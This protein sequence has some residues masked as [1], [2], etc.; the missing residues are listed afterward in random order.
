MHAFGWEKLITFS[1]Q[2]EKSEPA[3]QARTRTHTDL[4]DAVGVGELEL[5]DVCANLVHG[6]VQRQVRWQLLPRAVDR[7]CQ[8]PVGAAVGVRGRCCDCS[9]SHRTRR[10]GRSLAVCLKVGGKRHRIRVYAAA[11]QGQPGCL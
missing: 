6:G 11:S 3:S 8:L 2:H 10:D 7:N 9:G 1:T 4:G 5:K